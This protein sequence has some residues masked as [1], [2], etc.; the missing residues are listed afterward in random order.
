M[1]T[2]DFRCCQCGAIEEHYVYHSSQRICCPCGGETEKV[3]LSTGQAPTVIA[4]SI[5]GGLV[6]ENLTP[7]PR[8]YYS[9]SEIKRTADALGVEQR[10]RH[11]GEPGSDRSRHTTRW[12]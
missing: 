1:P 8:R 4:D 11:V 12:V 2:F 7:Q 10:V 6:I 5:P 3:W 9:R